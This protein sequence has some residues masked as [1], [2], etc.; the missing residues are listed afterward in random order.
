MP[1]KEL[2]NSEFLDSIIENIP[3]M[4]FI[5]DANN[6]RFVRFNKAGEE[7]LGY[8]RE[9]LIGKSDY[10]FFPKEEADFFT[11]KDR[12]VLAGKQPVDIPEEP[13]HTRLKG[14]RLLHTKK[15]PILGKKGEPR[16][17][18][19]ISEDITDL[20]ASQEELVHSRKQL[21]RFHAEKEQ[22][23]VF[24]YL[25]SHDLQEPLQKI[26][27]FGELLKGQTNGALDP[28]AKDY[29]ERMQN[30]ARRMTQLV[31]GLLSLSRIMAKKPHFE[32]VDLKKILQEVMSDLEVRV[33]KTGAK[34][35][36][37]TL[38]VVLADRSQMYQLFQNLISNAIKFRKKGESPRLSVTSRL[39]ENDHVEVC[40]RDNGIGFEE[41]DLG[42]LFKPFERLHGS[43]EYEGSGLG[44][45]ICQRIVLRHR[46]QITAQSKPGEGSAFFVRLPSGIQAAAREETAGVHER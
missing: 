32:T 19:G 37:D 14:R 43:G 6:L 36:S 29:V 22:M 33:L 20:R 42:R 38:S 41:R 45:A 30:A 11:S 23:E 28:K 15:I 12:A 27:S 2:E 4:I 31:Q 13:I 10:D 25:A 1:H 35:E 46:G 5:K 21:L 8:S 7:L 39:L 9:E 16:Y 17:L 24:A 40:F 34:I 3:H 26:I 44:L 18:L